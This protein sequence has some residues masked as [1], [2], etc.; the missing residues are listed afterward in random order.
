MRVQGVVSA[1]LQRPLAGSLEGV[2]GDNQ[3]GPSE[4]GDLYCVHTE[5]TYAP[6]TDDVAEPK[7]AAI[8]QSS[9]RSCNRVGNECG[10]LDRHM[11]GDC[12]QKAVM[13]NHILGPAAIISLTHDN[14]VEAVSEVATDAVSTNTTISPGQED[15]TLPACQRGTEGPT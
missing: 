1:K 3:A 5:A 7:S 2:D 14:G 8:D 15:D 4:A 9:E 12:C 10:L 13:N 11:I 6:E